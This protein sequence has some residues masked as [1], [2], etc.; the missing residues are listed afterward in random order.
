MKPPQAGEGDPSSHLLI[1]LMVKWL[2]CNESGQ[3][4]TGSGTRLQRN[5]I[6]S[7]ALRQVAGSGRR[8]CGGLFRGISFTKCVFE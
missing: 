5:V 8:Q 1:A 3:E 2:Q 7:N 6:S 4:K